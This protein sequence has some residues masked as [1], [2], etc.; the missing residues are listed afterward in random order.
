MKKMNKLDNKLEFIDDKILRIKQEMNSYYSY[1]V[2]KNCLKNTLN[3]LY[4]DRL[5]YKKE[6]SFLLKKKER[7]DKL[8]NILNE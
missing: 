2:R 4:N 8:K 7:Y 5:K 3:D 6:K 1:S